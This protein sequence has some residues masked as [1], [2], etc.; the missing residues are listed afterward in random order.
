MK[1]DFGCYFAQTFSY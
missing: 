1:G